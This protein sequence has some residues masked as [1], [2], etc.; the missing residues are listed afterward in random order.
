MRS[1]PVYDFVSAVPVT[2]EVPREPDAHY[3]TGDAAE[4]VACLGTADTRADTKHTSLTVR[5]AVLHNAV[6]GRD[7]QFVPKASLDMQ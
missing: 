3:V 4:V 1:T 6:L 2:D 5:S 7:E